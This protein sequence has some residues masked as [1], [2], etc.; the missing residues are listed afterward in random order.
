MF[1]WSAACAFHSPSITERTERMNGA[2]S[3][4]QTAKSNNRP[5]PAKLVTSTFSGSSC[6][7][8]TF[9]NQSSRSF[10][11]TFQSPKAIHGAACADRKPPRARSLR[12]FLPLTPMPWSR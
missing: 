1:I 5:S 7:P 4:A 11:S 12:R 3:L 6:V 9:S 10:G 8:T 2:R